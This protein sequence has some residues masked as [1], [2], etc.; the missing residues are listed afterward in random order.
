MDKSLSDQ[1]YLVDSHFHLDKICKKQGIETNNFDAM[2][3]PV[4]PG[5]H[6]SVRFPIKGVTCYML[7]LKYDSY[8]RKE[9]MS[10]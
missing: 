1:A 6:P 10:F 4:T 8:S 7:N 9:L 2:Y 3:S 5:A